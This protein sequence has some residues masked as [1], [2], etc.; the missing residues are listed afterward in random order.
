M[1]RRK[2]SVGI[3]QARRR[4]DRLGE[5]AYWYKVGKMRK[6]EGRKEGQLTFPSLSGLVFG[7]RLS[8]S[9]RIKR[10]GA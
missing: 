6:K 10:E 2:K 7:I 8:N 9:Q 5:A 3:A 4:R 1:E